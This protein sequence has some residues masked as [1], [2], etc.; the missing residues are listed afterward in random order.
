MS[1]DLKEKILDLLER[2][3]EFR[4]AVAGLIGLDEILKRLDE[5]DRKFNE[6]LTVLKEH[7][8]ILKEH[9]TRLDEHDRKFNEILASL[10]EHTA[11]LK[12]Y[13]ARLNEH[14]RK[15]NEILAKL[16]EH[17]R[18]FNEIV[19]R[20]DGHDRKF[21]EIISR[22]DE[23]DRK[24]NEIV[25]RLDA[26]D[27]KFNEIV[28]RLDEHDRKFNS[29]IAEIRDIRKELVDV[30]SYMERFSLTLE[31]E[32]WEVITSRL[33][34]IGVDVKLVRLTLPELEINI[35]GVA[36]DLCVV[37]KAS[38]RVGVG[39]LRSVDEKLTELRRRYPEY[40]RR[41]VLKVVYTMWATEDA[42]EEAKKRNIWLLK[43]LEDL[44]Q[45]NI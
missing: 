20:L 31:E 8:A 29:I 5:H 4:Y 13:A 32:A 39:V 24:F 43:G 11:I 37:G 30:K 2:D 41:R 3:R 40:L 14:D 35:Y 33:R 26:H 23:H 15:F 27:R 10:K 42:V 28:S 38:T 16:S 12:E 21:N 25:A 22:L 6:I 18:K 7:T 36:D 19:S 44:T 45:P 17:D 9:T 34:R 1:L